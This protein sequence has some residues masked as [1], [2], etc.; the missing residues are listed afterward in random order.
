[1]IKYVAKQVTLGRTSSF[2][3]LNS[4]IKLRTRVAIDLFSCLGHSPPP[5]SPTKSPNVLKCDIK[6]MRSTWN[7]KS[8]T[9]LINYLL[10][11]TYKVAIS[12]II[13]TMFSSPSR[14]M[15]SLIKSVRHQ[16]TSK[17]K[18]KNENNGRCKEVDENSIHLLGQ[19]IHHC[20][21]TLPLPHFHL[22]NNQLNVIDN[23]LKQG[24]LKLMIGGWLEPNP[25]NNNC[26]DHIL[27][28]Y[29]LGI[30]ERDVR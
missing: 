10:V 5:I 2:F 18:I 27:P 8:R 28:I 1:M 7:L 30:I 21:A 11:T 25:I 20:V 17:I 9:P 4:L 6:A 29:W 3:L 12:I 15:M 13:C 22:I 19:S 16:L 24:I 26:I 14:M 23:F